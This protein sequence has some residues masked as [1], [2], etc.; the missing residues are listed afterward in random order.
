MGIACCEL[1]RGAAGRPAAARLAASAARAGT[2][3]WNARPLAVEPA[4]ASTVTLAPLRLLASTL[5]R[6]RMPTLTMA[7]ALT[8]TGWKLKGDSFDTTTT[9]VF[10]CAC[11]VTS[12]AK[13]MSVVKY[14]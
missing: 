9:S 11:I 2:E 6:T 12:S 13:L 8:T 10:V 14:A 1:G 5:P 3:F 7:G 4:G